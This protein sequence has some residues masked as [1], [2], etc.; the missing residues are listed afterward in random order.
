M[1]LIISLL[2]VTAPDGFFLPAAAAEPGTG[3]MSLTAPQGGA[4][5]G[6]GGTLSRQPQAQ[7]RLSG[8]PQTEEPPNRCFQD[9]LADN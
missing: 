8:F 2:P 3:V 6:G 7:S 5:R 9:F 4:G 1:N